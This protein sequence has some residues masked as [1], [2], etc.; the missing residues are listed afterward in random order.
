MKALLLR[1]S[2]LDADAGNAVRVIAFFDALIRD[3][4]EPDTVARAAARLAERPVG[5]DAPG[6]AVLLRFAPDGTS[7]DPGA[8]PVRVATHDLGG[9]GCVWLEQPGGPLPLDAIVL[10]RLAIA[11]AGALGHRTLPAPELGDPALVELV[12]SR[13]AG[14]AE[15]SRA[16]HLL[17]LAP[18]RPVRLLAVDSGDG[19]VA[20]WAKS[21]F[22]A[23]GGMGN[24]I[25]TAALGEA[26]AVLTTEDP[27]ADRPAPPPGARVGVGTRVPA[28]QAWR[29]WQTARTAL[30]FAGRSVL[31]YTDATAHLTG[32]PV[33][34]WD[35]LGGFALLAEHLPAT[36]VAENADVAALHRLAAEPQGTALLTTLHAF[37]AAD[38]LRRAAVDLHLH[39]SSVADRISRA[40]AALDFPLT[41]PEGRARLTLA[42]VLRRLAAAADR[43][44][45]ETPGR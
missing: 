4:A 14:D 6:S 24:G 45:T 39:R 32:A 15:R 19:G 17:G 31:P 38:S 7:L 44:R 40:E 20:E 30:R 33:C 12:L 9:G 21:V 34:W 2:E 41:T 29:S 11:V 22:R 8:R 42:L 3:G 43:E 13:T 26:Y 5:V 16:L 37:C 25:R 27:P 23:C 18:A 35:A 10:E 28:A 36:A 1:L